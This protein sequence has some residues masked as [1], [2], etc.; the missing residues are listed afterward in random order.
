MLTRLRSLDLAL[1]IIPLL[2]ILLGITIIY[3]ITFPSVQFNLARAQIIYALLGLTIAAV[4][5]IID[6]RNWQNFSYIL[7]ALGFLLLVSVLYVGNKQFGAIRWLDF[8]PFQVQPSEIFKLIL[9]LILARFLSLWSGEMTISRFILVGLLA[10]VPISLV[11][12]QPDLGTTSVLAVITFGMLLFARLPWR[13]WLVVGSI[14]LLVSPFVYGSLKPYQK[15]R[16]HTFLAPRK[17]EAGKGYNVRQA[18]IAIG[19]GGLWGQGLGK[20]SQSQLNFLPVA[21]TDFIFAGLA[22][23]TG[24]LGCSVLLLLY[25]VLMARI[26]KIAEISQDYFGMYLAFGIGLMLGFQIFINI[27]MNLGIVPV[28]GIPLPFV[29]F[30]GT[31]LVINLASM[32][33]LQ[34]IYMRHKKI[35][36]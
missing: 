12:I 15:E 11:F 32:G 4:L 14:T 34:S 27:G 13:W 10:L 5:A 33:L 3:T 35:T 24:F 31:S 17:D 36:F 28:T 26:F 7:Y 2:L 1:L 20:G 29:S 23:A 6:Y 21:H 16:I 25:F 19:S 22:E 30:G 18:A 9:I 8:G